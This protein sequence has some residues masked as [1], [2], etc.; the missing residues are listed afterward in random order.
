MQAGILARSYR[1]AGGIV[2][3]AEGDPV[4]GRDSLDPGLD[5]FDVAGP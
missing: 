4:P 3:R 5:R 2:L 1:T